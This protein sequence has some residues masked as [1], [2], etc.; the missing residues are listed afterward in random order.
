[1]KL[2]CVELI[3]SLSDFSKQ[4]TCANYHQTKVKCKE[5]KKV[6]RLKESVPNFNGTLLAK[7]IIN[8]IHEVSAAYPS[9]HVHLRTFVYKEDIPHMK[10]QLRE[11]ASELVI[12]CINQLTLL[13][14]ELE[15]LIIP[16]IGTTARNLSPTPMPII[17]G[18]DDDE[19]DEE[20]M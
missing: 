4:I 2:Y 6:Y 7:S 1:M 11:K 20:D 8:Q 16:E 19:E 10:D 3:F 13:Q 14:E 17:D 12:E 9:P 15:V 5:K 18:I